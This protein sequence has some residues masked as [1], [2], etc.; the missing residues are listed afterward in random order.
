MKKNTQIT[1]CHLVF[2]VF[3][4]FSMPVHAHERQIPPSPFITIITADEIKEMGATD[5]DEVLKSV[6][7]LH[8]S[9]MWTGNAV[10]SFRGFHNGLDAQS[11]LLI[12]GLD[13]SMGYSMN[14]NSSWAGMPVEAIERIEVI[15]GP[16]PL[17]YSAPSFSGLIN[18]VTKRQVDIE[19]PEIGIRVGRFETQDAWVLGG[20]KWGG[21]EIAA[22]LEYHDTEGHK[23]IVEEDYQTY[24]DSLFD[25]E[26]SLA[27]GPANLQRNNYDL[28]LDIARGLW[29]F[30]A[31]WQRRRNAGY[32]TATQ[33]ILD[34]TLRHGSDRISA[35][36]TYYNPDL[37]QDWD[38]E[39]QLNYYNTSWIIP[40]PEKGKRVFPPGANLGYGVYPDGMR[41][42]PEVWENHSDLNLSTLYTGFK[43]HQ[44]RIAAGFHYTDL[45]QVRESKNFGPDPVTGAPLPPDS[46]M[47]DVTDTSSVYMK[48]GDRKNT[49][50]MLE[51][52]WDFAQN[53]SFSAGFRYDD[54]SDIREAISSRAT[55]HWT[56]TPKLNSY[57]SYNL[58]SRAPSFIELR[59]L[60]NPEL[61][62]NPNI[63]SEKINAIEWAV[64]YQPSNT[65]NLGANLFRYNWRDI[66][67]FEPD[68]GETT[69]TAQNI[70]NQTGS[71]MEVSIQ[72][73]ALQNLKLRGSYAF[74]RAIDKRYNAEAGKVPRHRIYANVHWR[75]LSNWSL[76]TQLNW[77]MDR[78]RQFSDD[79]PAIKD[80]QTVDLTL[81]SQKFNKHWEFSLAVR[82]A[83]DVDA[84]EPS[85]TREPV[86]NIPND[87]PLAGRSLLGEIRY[88]F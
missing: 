82:N 85:N 21:F 58:V 69:S 74:Q 87:Y 43:S 60:N 79:R 11:R 86:S 16:D 63:T 13:T 30:K 47:V 46:P 40:D 12:N 59:N 48:E 81:R 33:E 34:P 62:G 52:T 66:I 57:L 71:G 65:L 42:N 1:I 25:T 44:V 56:I 39:V 27:P 55:L 23:R 20:T 29:H 35:D 2:M 77:I 84:R 51:D 76:N 14:R 73:K 3:Y 88:I 54:F 10:Y 17:T 45:Y 5:L 67:A 80:Y 24:L 37:T 15:T 49:Y 8:V 75:F 50:F 78:K 38:L 26:A 9:I 61:I 70:G 64:A 72:W 83:F 31:G 36:L 28:R 18:V 68:P 6:P 7:G 4:I 22:V 32:Y 19:Q 41:G 53:W